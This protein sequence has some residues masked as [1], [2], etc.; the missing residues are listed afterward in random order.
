VSFSRDEQWVAYVTYPEGELWRSK[1]DDSQKLKLAS[2]MRALLV[3]WSPDGKRI[4]F[5]ARPPTV[6]LHIISA[7]VGTPEAL[8]LG[9]EPAD[10]CPRLGSSVDSG[11]IKAIA[12]SILISSDG[13]KAS[14]EIC[15]MRNFFASILFL[16]VG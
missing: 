15:Q 3:D 13:L 7:D 8:P 5:V 10:L 11:V 4:S 1:L 14:V 6:A 12:L 2:G 16:Q 9:G